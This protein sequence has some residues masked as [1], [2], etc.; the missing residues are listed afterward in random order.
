[1]CSLF[2]VLAPRNI[3]VPASDDADACSVCQT[4][5]FFA[6]K[7]ENLAI[8]ESLYRKLS[9]AVYNAIKHDHTH[10]SHTVVNATSSTT[11]TASCDSKHAAS[12][13]GHQAS[14]SACKWQYDSGIVTPQLATNVRFGT[15]QQT[16]DKHAP[17][18]N[19]A[20]LIAESSSD[21]TVYRK[22]DIKADLLSQCRSSDRMLDENISQC[23]LDATPVLL[24][25]SHTICRGC[26]HTYA[27]T[28]ACAKPGT[29]FVVV[30]CP[31]RC[32]RN[33]AFICDLGVEWL[34]I[35][36]HRIRLLQEQYKAPHI[37]V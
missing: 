7:E 4:S 18:G 26:T 17:L 20:P 1:M 29:K 10:H 8:R 11:S 27:R 21:V 19:T 16:M 14:D 32:H 12:A 31:R 30:D 23:D 36:V 28:D 13:H 5:F 15:T 9:E 3:A 34:P 6:Y 25:C 33:T 35:D 2:I 24:H 22:Y 37:N